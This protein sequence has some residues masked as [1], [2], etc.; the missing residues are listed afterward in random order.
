MLTTLVYNQNFPI[1][2]YF[3]LFLKFIN[4]ISDYFHAFCFM[5]PL[6]NEEKPSVPQ[7][8]TRYLSLGEAQEPQLVS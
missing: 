6:I 3:N 8:S 1:R 2:L 4:N 5:H 7:N